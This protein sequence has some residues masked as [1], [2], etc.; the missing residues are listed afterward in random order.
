MQENLM[1]SISEENKGKKKR[2]ETNVDEDTELS[3]PICW[4]LM[5]APT[6]NTEEKNRD[7][8]IK[9]RFAK[10]MCYS[11]CAAALYML[12]ANA[13]AGVVDPKNWTGI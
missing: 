12:Q 5:D 13:A 4:L 1:P 11:C 8:F 7:F 3:Q 10:Q 9:R 6:K 2:N